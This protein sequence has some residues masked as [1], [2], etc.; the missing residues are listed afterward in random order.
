M[1]LPKLPVPMRTAPS[2]ADRSLAYRPVNRSRAM[3]RYAEEPDWLENLA[4]RTL[5][6]SLQAQSHIHRDG[7][8]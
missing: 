5:R 2:G 3:A 4:E 1:L 8:R 6:A 7:R